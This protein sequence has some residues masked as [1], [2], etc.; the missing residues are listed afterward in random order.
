MPAGPSAQDNGGRHLA[1][2]WDS[3]TNTGLAQ[4]GA[5]VDVGTGYADS[6]VVLYD[7]GGNPLIFDSGK[8]RVSLYD[9]AGNALAAQTAGADTE[10]NTANALRSAS[11]LYTFNGTTWDRLRSVA[12]G[13]GTPGTGVLGTSNNMWD[14]VSSVYRPNYSARTV[15]DGD[16]GANVQAEGKYQFNGTTWDRERNNTEGTLLALASRTAA[17][18]TVLPNHNGRYLML[19]ISF[20]SRAG[21][22][23]M[24]IV[25][26]EAGGGS[27]A[28]VSSIATPPGTNAVIAIGPGIVQSDM[29]TNYS[30][31]GVFARSV[32]LPRSILIDV[33]PTDSTSLTY[34][35]MYSLTR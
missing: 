15:P 34:Q 27:Y 32:P 2:P 26:R 13:G 9:S 1:G 17:T 4:R 19:Y 7:A 8:A 20:A 24:L 29:V 22:P 28:A 14:A 33:V 5:N 3:A 30:T 23:T 18:S 12:G 16:A 11:R 25:I 31:G 35:V 10:A 21:T 6:R